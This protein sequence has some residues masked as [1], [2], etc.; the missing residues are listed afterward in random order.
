MKVRGSRRY[1]YE[2]TVLYC[3]REKKAGG[4]GW[5]TRRCWDRE[6]KKGYL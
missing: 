4:G 3:R 2:S 5:D 1:M 6:S